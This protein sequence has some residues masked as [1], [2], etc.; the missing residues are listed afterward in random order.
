MASLWPIPI[1]FAWV[2]LR[3]GLLSPVLPF[4]LPLFGNQPGMIFWFLLW[5]I[6]LRMYFSRVWRKL[7][8]RKREPLS[9]QKIMY[10]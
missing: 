1:M 10:P 7:Q 8:L 9:D 3:F 5:Y 4:E 6:P 2:K